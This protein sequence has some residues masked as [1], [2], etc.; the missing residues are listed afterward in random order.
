MTR[1]RRPTAGPSPSPLD[2]YFREIDAT[3]LL[4]AEEERRLACRVQQGDPEARDHL[5][6]ANL[7][8]VVKIARGYAGRGVDLNDLI[9]EGNLGLLRAAE[10]F[11]PEMGTRFSTY[12]SYWAEQSVQRA[13][14]R[15]AHAVRI[16]AYA[17]Q[18][19]VKWRHAVARLRDELGRPPTHEE[20]AQALGLKPRQLQIARKALRVYAGSAQA[21]EGGPGLD[22]FLPDDRAGEPAAALGR[23]EELTQVLGMLDRLEGRAATVVRLRFGL[24]G[25][26][27]MTL[28]DVGAR[29]GLTRERVRQI[30]GE[31]LEK[32]REELGGN[33]EAVE[34]PHRRAEESSTGMVRRVRPRQGRGDGKT[35]RLP[36]RPPACC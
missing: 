1:L 25:G 34:K 30:E 32:L 9:A 6:R 27:P 33:A 12:A 19:L 3:P 4:S 7:R 36:A 16:P 22:E 8:L 15:T 28:A 13:V 17:A 24:G 2:T 23:A 5:V 11:D 18:L 26:E 20:T 21:E 29:L 14:V 31:A 10:G 35:G